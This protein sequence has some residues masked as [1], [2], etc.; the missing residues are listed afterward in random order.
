MAEEKKRLI[1]GIAGESGAGKD[2]AASF[3][4]QQLKLL[5][6]EDALQYE[7]ARPLKQVGM[8][9]G[10]EQSEVYGR[11]DEKLKVNDDWN[12]SGRIWMQRFGTEICRDTLPTI[13]PESTFA[14]QLW[15]NLFKKFTRKNSAHIVVSDV[16][17]ADEAKAIQE[18]GGIV[19]GIVRPSAANDEKNSADTFRAHV[20]ETGVAEISH[21]ILITNDGTLDDFEKEVVACVRS[22]KFFAM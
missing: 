6:K 15:I 4:L 19:I 11:Q 17:R 21:D 8:I 9:L 14:Q 18:I 1:I 13:F 12:V 3:I 20:S 5:S 2:T 7:F 10:F 16:R 22:L